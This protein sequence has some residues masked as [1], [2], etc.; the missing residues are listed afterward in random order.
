MCDFEF[1]SQIKSD[2]G[3]PKLEYKPGPL[4]DFFMQSFRNKLVE[5][6]C[7]IDIFLVSS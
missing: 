4:D 2:E 7:E 1:D 6:S 3:S 5:V